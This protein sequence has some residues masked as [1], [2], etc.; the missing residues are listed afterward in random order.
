MK[1][2]V[3]EAL[4]ESVFAMAMRAQPHEEVAGN[5]ADSQKANEEFSLVH[6]ALRLSL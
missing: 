1:K 4:D 2:R 3:E 6:N 5:Q